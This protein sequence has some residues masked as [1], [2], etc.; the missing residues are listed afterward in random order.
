[1]ITFG[2]SPAR[3][4]EPDGLRVRTLRAVWY[5][6][7]HIAHPV[8]PGLFAALSGADL[9]H[10]HHMRST[11]SRLAA[12]RARAGRQRLVVTDHGLT[13]GDWGGILPRLFDRFLMVSAYSARVLGAPPGRTDVIYGGADPVRHAPDPSVDR[14]GVLFVGRLTPHK[15]VDRL[16][17]ALPAGAR[18][19]VAG[20]TG[21]DPNL[22]ERDY[23]ALLR[24]LAAGR[25]VDF[26]GPV[27]DDTLPDL[28]GRAA[29]LV[30]PS[31]HRTVYG[32][33]IA[34]SELLGLTVLEA[35]ASG[36]PVIASRVGG[37]P[38]IVRHG[39]TGCLVEPGDI[40]ELHDRLAE[41]LANPRLARRLGDNARTA[42]LERFTWPKVA[43]RC[44]AAYEAL[45]KAAPDQH[46]S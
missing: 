28:Y 5:R 32:R 15:G 40:G 24:Q 42:V 41:I 18:L 13:G 45:L 12:L 14:S 39:E 44:L 37:V 30:L 23:P 25:D 43:E 4:R 29:V 11:P 17:Q 27:P 19:T 1:M 6:G 9:I 8:A 26:T 38:E 7:G 35:M 16:I 31:V 21:H 20:S 33:D 22:P 3:L 10:T 46:G 36:T 2:R 34:V